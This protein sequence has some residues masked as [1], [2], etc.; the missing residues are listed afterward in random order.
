[1]SRSA[2]SCG[3]PG[4]IRRVVDEVTVAGRGASRG[5]QG[6]GATD[7]RGLGARVAPSRSRADSS[8][9]Q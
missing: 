1:M 6:A 3:P 4:L 8:D 2:R 9:H 7:G 5:S